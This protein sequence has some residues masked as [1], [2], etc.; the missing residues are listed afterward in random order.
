MRTFYGPSNQYV[1]YTTRGPGDCSPPDAPD[2]PDDGQVMSGYC[3]EDAAPEGARY[4][5]DCGGDL[6]YDSKAHEVVCS[7]CG[8]SR[9]WDEYME[10]V[11]SP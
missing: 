9:P 5:E 1:R 6:L 4:H 7:E 10:D 3:T 2:F 11:N 8:H